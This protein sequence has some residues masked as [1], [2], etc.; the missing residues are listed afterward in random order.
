MS[1]S[2]SIP[3]SARGSSAPTG[4]ASPRCCGS[5]REKRRLTKAEWCW[6]AAHRRHSCP[7]DSRQTRLRRSAASSGGALADHGEAQAALRSIERRMAQASGFQLESLMWKYSRAYDDFE[8]LGGYDVDRR[9]AAVLEGL[10]LGT[11][12]EDTPVSVLSGGQRTRAGLAGVIASEP[13]V[14]LLDEPTNHLDI[15]ALEWLESWLSAYEGAALIV[16]HDRTFLDLSVTRILELNDRSHGLRAYPGNYS[17]HRHAKERELEKQTAMWK[18]QE[19]EA[20][21][22]RGRHR[23]HQADGAS[24]G[25]FH[26]ARLLPEACKEGG[27]EG[28]GAGE[29]AGAHDRL[30]G[31]SRAA[32]GVVGHEAGLRPD[33]TRW[34]ARARVG[35]RRPRLRWAL[36]VPGCEPDARAWRAHCPAGPERLR[37]DNVAANGGREC[38]PFL[39]RRQAG[40]KRQDR[41]H[42][43]GPGRSGLGHVR[44]GDCS[45]R[46]RH[47]GDRGED[48]SC[49]STCS[50]AT[51]R[52][53]RPP[54]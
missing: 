38:A 43:A 33:A 7:R 29:Q 36:V 2:S 3:A 22:L 31:P 10:G 32:E 47:D 46:G 54:V 25:D 1:P 5:S 34:V 6:V 18:D 40:R 28:Q 4:A 44:L 51:T 19:A 12:P 11:V 23:P 14:L 15:E 17:S 50:K 41:V 16:S 21:K 9:V 24:H 53:F 37:E 45:K 8:A 35:G 20:R 26:H 30:L 39:G 42:A 13:T 49:T 27:P 48:V 52:Y